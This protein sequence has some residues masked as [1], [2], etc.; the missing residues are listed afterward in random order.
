MEIKNINFKIYD[1]INVL[2]KINID[3][4]K[5]K[6]IY[7]VRENIFPGYLESG[8]KY[9]PETEN[10][11][12]KYNLKNI[13]KEILKKD[14]ILKYINANNIL[15]KLIKVNLQED[16]SNY[17][18]NIKYIEKEKE[19]NIC[20][21]SFYEY[22]EEI[23]EILKVFLKYN[24]ILDEKTI[25]DAK[26]SLYRKHISKILLNALDKDNISVPVLKKAYQIYLDSCIEI[27]QQS[28]DLYECVLLKKNGKRSFNIFIPYGKLESLTFNYKLD[29]ADFLAFIFLLNEEE[30]LISRG[31]NYI[32][33]KE[34]E[35]EKLKEIEKEK[36]K[37]NKEIEK[38]EK[39]IKDSNYKDKFSKV[40]NQIKNIIPFF[41]EGEKLNKEILIN[42]ISPILFK[43]ENK[44]TKIDDIFKVLNDNLDFNIKKDQK[45][46]LVNF[47]SIFSLEL[48]KHNIIEN[49]SI[50]EDPYNLV[51]DKIINNKKLNELIKNSR[52]RDKK[53]LKKDYIPKT[54]ESYYFRE[55]ELKKH[56][57]IGE[58]D[59]N[60]NKQVDF[61][62]YKIREAIYKNDIVNKKAKK[63]PIENLNVICIDDELI[64]GKNKVHILGSI[65]LNNLEY[66]IGV[67]DLNSLEDLNKL[68][69]YVNKFILSIY[70]HIK[71]E[72]S[73][74]TD[75]FLKYIIDTIKE[76]DNTYLE[77]YI[78]SLAL[79]DI[80]KL[81]NL[82][83]IDT[84]TYNNSFKFFKKELKEGKS[85]VEFLWDKEE[86]IKSNNS[87]EDGNFKNKILNKDDENKK[88]KVLKSL[89]KD[90]QS[91][92]I[93]LKDININLENIDILNDSNRIGNINN[94]L[95][96]NKD[97]NKTINDIKNNNSI[98]LEKRIILSKF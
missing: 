9:I 16:F 20:I 53:A 22:P 6:Y 8:I 90:I 19:K 24:N 71:F 15:K 31:K 25:N 93:D 30:R 94:S 26:N 68:K 21:K 44:K 97:N 98:N 59:N 34:E 11:V 17:E 29:E 33:I 78:N 64:T 12:S 86:Y 39:V 74:L 66:L 32:N 3:F 61:N 18:F 72:E 62:I 67:K 81:Y 23:K 56:I 43:D 7:N 37:K 49:I 88:D 13:E 51:L 80:N 42:T 2:E 1:D 85:Y 48:E 55:F 92:N 83:I 65:K 14:E 79:L 10:K 52:G 5:G 54:I 47:L 35:K 75:I 40:V 87:S 63:L 38:E 96:I 77:D 73:F 46:Y 45:L 28:K 50:K 70:K 27:I 69:I 95:N 58:K 4:E 41:S 91:L 76:I 84:E 89:S 82:S 57:K 36:I 60:L